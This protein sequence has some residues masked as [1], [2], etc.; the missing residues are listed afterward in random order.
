MLFGISENFNKVIVLSN[1]VINLLLKYFEIELFLQSA[2]KLRFTSHFPP[3]YYQV[4]LRADN[5][6]DQ[7][8]IWFKYSYLTDIR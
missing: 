8:N 7:F 3:F 5:Q 2:A 1:S 6:D 4:V